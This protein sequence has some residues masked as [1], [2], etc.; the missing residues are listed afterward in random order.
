MNTTVNYAGFHD[1]E[2][3]NA[4]AIRSEEEEFKEIT[5]R[6]TNGKNNKCLYNNF[7]F[8]FYIIISDIMR[9]Y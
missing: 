9:Y 2:K 1:K 8:H 6:I 4:V 7:L 5:L 3:K